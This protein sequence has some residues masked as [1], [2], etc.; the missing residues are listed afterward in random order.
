M[1]NPKHLAILK[2]GVEVWN[3]WRSHQKQSDID[4]SEADLGMADLR[5][6]NLSTANLCKVRLP[7]ANLCKANLHKACLREALLDFTDLSQANL[8]SADLLNA[9]LICAHLRETNLSD[10]NLRGTLSTGADFSDANLSGANLNDATFAVANF[11][12][13][14]LR[15]A[16]LV[17]AR[18]HK[19]DLRGADLRSANLQC[20][21][22]VEAN[23]Y[24]AV[25]TGCWVYGVSAWGNEMGPTT[26]EQDLVITPP[27]QPVVTVD[28]L[29]VAQF[30]YL[31]L[32][33]QKIR[34]AIDAIG[35][36]VVLILGRFY[37]ERKAVL[38]A[39]RERLREFD[40]VPIVFDFDKPTRRD[41]TE[42]VQLLSNMSRFI[43][44]DVTDAKSIPQELSHIIPFLPSVPVRPIVLDVGEPYSM[45]EHWE[46]F[47]SVLDVYPYENRD[48]LVANIEYGIIE[49]IKEWELGFD[50]RKALREKA[51]AL[52]ARVR[53]LETQ[54]E[55]QSRSE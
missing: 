19:A 52:E 39:L 22:L 15:H 41:L 21:S 9:Q 47:D 43:I 4:L 29:E 36:K 53:E 3:E 32:H 55:I 24:D 51:E 50:Q 17:L 35:R 11:S 46:S 48:H 49:P 40:F 28:G 8:N 44:A 34:G 37:D 5:G 16:D 23:L 1:A 7:G 30:V 38:D 2:Q 10:G 42:T 12:R 25:L 18:L 20:A 45:F 31:M 14:N 54:L 33:N 27:D 13:A 6:A 26:V